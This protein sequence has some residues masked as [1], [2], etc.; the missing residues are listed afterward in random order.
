[1]PARPERIELPTPFP[2][3]GVNAYYVPGDV[4]GLVDTGTRS[5][6]ARRALEEALE[7]LAVECVVVTHGHVDHFGLAAHL[8][9][10]RGAEILVHKAD[11][12]VL[13]DYDRVAKRRTE[14]HEEGLRR[15]GVPDG[16]VERMR[17]EAQR[18]DAWAEAVEVDRT[19]GHGDHVGLGDVEYEVLHAPGHTPG[20]M[21]LRSP[22]AAHTFTGD[23]LLERI[24][25]N[26]L[27]VR[28][29]DEDALATYLATLRRL[30][31]EEL[32][33]ILPGH[34]TPFEG[35][36]E[37]VRRALRHADLRQE[38]ILE[39]LQEGP[40]TAYEVAQSLFRRL[41]ADQLFLAVSEVLGHLNALR[42]ADEVE[43]E[44]ADG[45]ERWRRAEEEG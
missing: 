28:N 45:T 19:L 14:S 15:A 39:T 12:D 2:V 10:T 38:R 33:T 41:P 26:A 17:K 24:T 4:P 25:P 34:R 23:T 20:S 30:G 3:G 9:R 6:P 22:E 16:E 43:T 1:M 32:G 18:F 5:G 21:L 31:D 44:D 42:N 7:G 37:A 13:S 8:K 35:H 40:R 29:E 27:S 11:A 36:H